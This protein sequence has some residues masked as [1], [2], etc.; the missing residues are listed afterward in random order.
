MLNQVSMGVTRRPL[1]GWS[2]VLTSNSPR[3]HAG[4]ASDFNAGDKQ[5]GC[6]GL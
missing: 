3:A 6:R 4:N 5:R 1:A 2:E